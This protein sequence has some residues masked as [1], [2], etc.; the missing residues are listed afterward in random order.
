M[1]NSL[2]QWPP[3]RHFVAIG[4]LVALAPIVSASAAL[5]SP[6]TATSH[7]TPFLQWGPNYGYCGEASFI[8]A[9][10]RFG[11]YTSQWTAR[12]VASSRANQTLPASQLL[13]GTS[14][15]DG[16][17]QTA[18]AAMRLNLDTYDSAHQTSTQ[19]YLVWIKRHV[20]QGDPV[21]MGVLN[22]VNMLGQD[23]PG[24]TEYDHIVPVL[25]VGSDR[26]L[27]GDNVGAYVPTDTLTISDNGLDGLGARPFTYSFGAVQRTRRQANQGRALANLYSVLSP[28][29]PAAS[30]Y[31]VAVTGVADDSPGG[32]YA[33]PVT[34]ASSRNNE[35]F[36]DADPMPRPPA[37]KRTNLTVAVSIP[38]AGTAYRLYEYTSFAAVPRGSFNAAAASAPKSVAHTWEIPAGS[39]DRFTVR[40]PNVSTAGT[41]VFRAVP[42]SAP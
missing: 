9:G 41:Y 16:N 28:V 31:A 42:V 19:D 7:V 4:A 33:I 20:V 12:R 27:Q 32:P 18:A 6:Y 3:T 1:T 15:P 34:V 14:L 35:G 39:G 30:D 23:P 24:D 22:N 40:L 37:A 36:P 13:L 21:I 26:P 25:A 10:M 38:D 11:Q 5:A 17:A 8:A 29:S 2:R